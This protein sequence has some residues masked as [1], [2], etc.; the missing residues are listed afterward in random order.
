[1]LGFYGAWSNLGARF[2]LPLNSHHLEVRFNGHLLHINM[3]WLWQ[4]LKG[5]VLL[6][7]A[8]QHPRPSLKW[9]MHRNPLLQRQSGHH[10]LSDSSGHMNLKHLSAVSQSSDT[11]L[12]SS[13]ISMDV[14]FSH[15]GC[16]TGSSSA[17]SQCY[18]TA[19]CL[20]CIT[21]WYA[22]KWTFSSSEMDGPSHTWSL[23]SIKHACS[24]LK[25]RQHQKKNQ[26]NQK[27]TTKNPQTKTGLNSF[28]LQF[29]LIR[30]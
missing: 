20:S 3:Q 17:R 14:K 11:I 9:P 12:K 10:C 13:V 16:Q 24:S 30:V 21:L 1:M 19:A 28:F 29:S 7:S 27:Q 22:Q 2:N 6:F 23:Q 4:A 25:N 8:Q 5:S 15:L 26:Q 18:D